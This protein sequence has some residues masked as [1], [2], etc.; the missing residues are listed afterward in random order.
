MNSC[1]AIFI[2]LLTLAAVGCQKANDDISSSHLPQPDASDRHATGHSTSDRTSAATSDKTAVLLDGK[3]V[4]W[5]TLHAPFAEAA[6]TGILSE[7]LTDRLVEKELKRRGMRITDS[8]IDTEQVAFLASLDDDPAQAARLLD[9]VRQRRGLG[10]VR[11]KMMLRRNAALRK[12]VSENITISDED[13]R[14]AY[15]LVY[16]DRYQAR[17]ITL[18]NAGDARRVV[19]SARANN[20]S[21]HFVDLVMQHS[22][23]ASKQRGGL[24][25]PISPEDP[26]YP[27]AIRKAL[28]TLETGQVGDPVALPDGGVGILRLE[29]KIT[30]G[31]VRLS[32]V[33][34]ELRQRV[35]R[36]R[37]SVAMQELNRQLLREA[38]IIVLDR[39][40]NEAW[41]QR[42]P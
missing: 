17:L 19:E 29:R 27:L 38:S 2:G 24:L 22:T 11:Y 20:T 35:L 37:Q 1:L 21:A 10:P 32:D 6:G 30:G 8:D 16:G 7:V 31:H 23:D 3:P 39:H 33:K 13:V 9:Q 25:A 36:Q 41:R 26:T 40:L 4:A 14:N 18:S 5:Q 42:N 12:L 28:Q 15:E 34:G